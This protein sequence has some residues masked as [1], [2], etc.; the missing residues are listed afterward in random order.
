MWLTDD[1]RPFQLLGNAHWI[2]PF[3]LDR[4]RDA[5][6]EEDGL[7][8]GQLIIKASPPSATDAPAPNTGAG[9]I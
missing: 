6:N 9:P 2:G 7:E 3:K 4:T 1:Q 5:W 8:H